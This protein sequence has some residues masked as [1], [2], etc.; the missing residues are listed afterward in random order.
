VAN[1]KDPRASSPTDFH[2]GGW[3]VQPS[4]NVIAQG[5]T[6]RHLEPQVMDLLAFLA[7]TGG[8]V[9]SKDE[10]IDAVWQG[11]F[12]A[13]ATL[14]RTMADLRRALGDD[15]RT[16]Q[17]IDTIPKRGYRLAAPVSAASEMERAP[18]QAVTTQTHEPVERALEPP[19]SA[20]A[21][22]ESCEH[23]GVRE[24]IAERLASARRSRFVGRAAELEV[25]RSALRSDELPFVALHLSGAGG[26]GKTTLIHE[27]AR[28]AEEMGRAAV[29]IDGRNIEPSATG[30]VAALGEAI[31][32]ERLDLPAVMARWPAGAVLLVDTYEHLAPLDDWLRQ[33]FLPQLPAQTLVVIAGRDEPAAAW[34]TDVAWAP[35]TRINFLGNLDADESRTFLTKCG[36]PRHHHDEAMAFTRG[37][38]LALSLIADML[39]RTDRFAPSRLDSEPEIVRLLLETFVQKIPTR[40]HRLALHTCVTVWATTETLLA[41]VLERSDVH[42]IFDWLARLPFVELGPYGLFPHDLARD[43]VYMDFRWRD[44]DAAYRVTERVLG[45]LYE[46]LDRTRGLDR[47]RVWFDI[48]FVQRYNAGLRPYFEWA[49]FGTAYAETAQAH[50]HPAILA[51][52][53]RH[54]GRESASIARY[55][56]TRQ[57][58][59]FHAIRQVDGGL[60][61]F[62]ANLSLETV[63][64]ED[65]A[66]DPAVARAMAHVEAHSPPG[67]GERVLYG[68]FWMHAERHQAITQVF[69]VVGAMCSQSWIG[70]KV[71]WSFV[72]MA[73]PDLTEP[74]FTEIHIWRL[75]EADFEVGG[76]RY[77]VFAH[78]WR[79][80][81]AQEWLRLKAERASR[82][83][84]AITKAQ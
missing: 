77:G 1:R 58:E 56:L 36:V 13:E 67:P 24:R 47:Q 18:Q 68:R 71:A 5:G 46:R 12:I 26:V 52:V 79:V 45:Y 35:L 29:C 82:I 27:F 69:T 32:A 28:V 57:P 3:F 2:V 15:H 55:W 84:G 39:T 80:E 59:A 65:A 78:D 37:H 40:D 60:I 38:P 41:T 73:D 8:R 49:G 19:F 54:E 17:Y 23:R 61:G 22:R 51:M 74:M 33:S 10:I 62:L 50:E 83:E 21:T 42:E 63:T 34:R 31:G 9:V 70:P 64:P 14:T 4:L 72:T 48:L 30:F 81:P 7:S 11:R 16:R 43:V 76:R 66:A 75:R 44:P 6:V 25:F 20:Q 53:E